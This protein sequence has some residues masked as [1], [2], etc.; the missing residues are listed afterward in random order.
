MQFS[1]QKEME[2]Y[3]SEKVAK[4]Y[5]KSLLETNPDIIEMIAESTKKVLD[6]AF[7][8]SDYESKAQ[9]KNLV[10]E[11]DI[12]EMVLSLYHTIL[13][14]PSP[15]ITLANC[16]TQFAASLKMEERVSS[17]KLA[18]ELI[19]VCEGNFYTLARFKERGSYYVL[20][21]LTLDA[22][23][24]QIASRAMYMPPAWAYKRISHNRDSLYEIK[25]GSSVI[26]GG[27]MNHHDKNL[28]LD[29]LNKLNSVPLKLDYEFVSNNEPLIKDLIEFRDVLNN[30]G[31]PK[32]MIE[33]V[34]AQYVQNMNVHEQ[35]AKEVYEIFK[36]KHFFLENKY[37]K[38]GRIYAQGHHINP[39]GDSY[40]KASVELAIQNV[41][42]GEL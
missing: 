5:V 29:A 6:W 26:L 28:A 30:S 4:D 27:S 19:T 24:Y 15:V 21:S 17:I 23:E 38:R 12:P 8:P 31:M 40:K 35:Q 41:V 20:A 9:R 3:Y 18:G 33:Q 2:H 34:V 42:T 10:R 22:E 36:D 32:D 16:A 37:D 13:L 25:Q 11:M 1:C 39:Q 7:S 14:Q